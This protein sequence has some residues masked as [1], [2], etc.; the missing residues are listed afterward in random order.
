MRTLERRLP[1]FARAVLASSILFAGVTSAEEK[2]RSPDEVRTA[3]RDYAALRAAN[4]EMM[5]AKCERLGFGAPLNRAV[6]GQTSDLD[7]LAASD[8]FD[9]CVLKQEIE[10]RIAIHCSGQTSA[11]TCRG[12]LWERLMPVTPTVAESARE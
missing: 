2:P 7:L 9:A 4:L 5:A 6:L 12:A 10:L 1:R 3:E 11:E 8:L